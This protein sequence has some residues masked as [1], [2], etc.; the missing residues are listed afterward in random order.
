[1]LRLAAEP[2]ALSRV[3]AGGGVLSERAARVLARIGWP[4]KP[5]M[6]ALTPLTTA[7]QQRFDNGREVYRNVCQTCHQ[8]DGRGQDKI[9]ASLIGSELALAQPDVTAR[10]LLNGKEGSIGLMPP[11]GQTLSDEQIAD[12]LTYVRR[13]WG[14]TGSPVAPGTVTAVRALTAGR[15]KPWTNDELRALAAGGH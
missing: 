5:G 14:Q 11:V 1:M 15:A 7:E 3:A 9:A 13:A 4:G 6:E 10:I 2:A 12:V 8:P